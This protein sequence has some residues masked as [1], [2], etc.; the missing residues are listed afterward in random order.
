MTLVDTADWRVAVAAAALTAPPFNAP[1]LF[2]DG[3]D[4]PGPSTT[5]LK[6]LNPKGADAAGNA[7]IIRI[8][9]VAAPAGYAVHRPRR[10]RR[11]SR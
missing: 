9:N 7:Q 11:R 5:A 8:G 3:T 10:R 6:A 1:V 2:S 4:L